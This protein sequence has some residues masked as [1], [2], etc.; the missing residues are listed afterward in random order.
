MARSKPNGGQQAL[1]GFGWQYLSAMAEGLSNLV[2]LAVLARLLSPADFGL[3]SLALVFSGF[4]LMISQVGVGP[5]LVQESELTPRQISTGFVLSLATGVGSAAILAACA[6]LI[7]LATAN[8]AVVPVVAALSLTMLFGALGTVP[9]ALLTRELR[10]RTLMFVSLASFVGYAA[11]GIVAALA[12]LGVWALVVATVGQ[13]LVKAVL[14]LGCARRSVGFRYS[15]EDARGILGYGA[16]FTLARL[17]NY[18]A[19]KGDN[20]VVGRLLGDA[21]LGHYSRAF[22]LMMLPSYYLATAMEKV[23]FPI[24]SRAAEDPVRLRRIYLTGAELVGLLCVPISLVM[25][26]LAREIVLTLLGPKWTEVVLPL[27]ILSAG[28]LFR[29]TY[30]FGDSLAK[31]TGAVYQRSI[32]EGIY[33]ALIIVGAAVGCR[34]GLAGVSTGVLFAVGANY[35]MAASMSRRILNLNAA[36]YVSAHAPG[37]LVGLAAAAGALVVKLALGRIVPAP[38]TLVLASLVALVAAVAF[39]KWQPRALGEGLPTLLGMLEERGGI[40]A[41]VALSRRLLGL[42]PAAA[43]P[44]ISPAV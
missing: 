41:R 1:A 42:R 2:V 35:A 37:I 20:F 7:G 9:E 14:L 11:V 3:M 18:A 15:K 39:A 44:P 31:A 4:S 12:G 6:P 22:A 33:A 17:L 19:N 5:A 23:L 36:D 32:R 10:F 38:I 40:V 29:T 25:I 30:K 8:P 26:V 27:Q 34:W 13:T 21:T 28:I 24:M 43:E 16:G